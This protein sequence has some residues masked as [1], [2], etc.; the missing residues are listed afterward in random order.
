MKHFFRKSI[1][2]CLV[3]SVLF[4]VGT[5]SGCGGGSDTDKT[6]EPA[7]AVLE[8]VAAK[9]LKIGVL[10]PE[11]S[12]ATSV[13]FYQLSGLEKAAEATKLDVAN[14]IVIKKTVSDI[15]FDAKKSFSAQTT[16]T[17][18]ETETSEKTTKADKKATT[19]KS[20]AIKNETVLEAVASLVSGDCHVIVA[21]SEIY[22][23]ITAYLAGQLPDTV[24]LQYG[25]G[26]TKLA[27]L[28]YYSDRMYE[29]FY[30]AGTAAA[31]LSKNKTAGF[32]RAETSN[33]SAA[34]VNAFANGMTA[35]DAKSSVKLATTGVK[36]DL[37]LERTLAEGL[38]TDGKCDVITQSVV[39]ALPQVA[40][41]TG[42]KYCFGFGYDMSPDA[43]KYSVFS[44][45][46]NW[47]VFFKS[48]ITDITAGKLTSKA[49][50]GGLSDGLVGI[51]KIYIENEALT[52]AVS[53]AKAKIISGEIK[54]LAGA[55]SD[56]SFVKAVK[57]V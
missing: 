46:W 36:L 44:V 37:V 19:S 25:K 27:N 20:I 8:A 39:T 15:T 33:T 52:K 31:T 13:F 6:T 50:N 56:G 34:Y 47:D 17:T 53:D 57:V 14:Q 54:P 40:A 18:T 7:E 10:V 35:A 2:L 28:K 11:S 49:Y 29:A 23:E 16:A 3:L 41:E 9:D 43:P 32:V 55:P 1:S 42:K 51:T 4:T 38:I 12:N 5:M 22:N 26:S 21:V 30:L 24:F 45:V 48:V